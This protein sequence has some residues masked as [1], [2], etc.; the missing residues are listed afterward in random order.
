MSDQSITQRPALGMTIKNLRA[1]LP[2]R[3]ALNWA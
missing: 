2:E 3:A 1:S